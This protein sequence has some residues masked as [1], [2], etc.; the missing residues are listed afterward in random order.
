MFKKALL[1]DRMDFTE[2]FSVG[3]IIPRHMEPDKK[4]FISPKIILN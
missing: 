4:K 1:R 3:W 2:D